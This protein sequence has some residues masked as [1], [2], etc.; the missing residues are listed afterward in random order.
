[1][2]AASEVFAGAVRRHK[3][4][5]VLLTGGKHGAVEGNNRARPSLHTSE[6]NVVKD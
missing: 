4:P 2:S 6:R 3:A 5:P 1:M